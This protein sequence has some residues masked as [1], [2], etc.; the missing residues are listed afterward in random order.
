MLKSHSIPET[1]IS[2]CYCFVFQLPADRRGHYN[3]IQLGQECIDPFFR[4][5]GVDVNT[6][7]RC[8]ERN[9]EVIHRDSIQTRGSTGILEYSFSIGGM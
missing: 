4:V 6:D 5:P 2:P 8:S 7:I 3:R 1:I 9:K